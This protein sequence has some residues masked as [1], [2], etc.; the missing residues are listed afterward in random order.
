MASI[1]SDGNLCHYLPDLALG[2][3]LL[4]FLVTMYESVEVIP[5]A[6]L[7]THTKSDV[8][9]RDRMQDKDVESEQ[10]LLTSMKM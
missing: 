4:P 5:G 8:S 3:G 9:A 6:E 2:E 10:G 7:A 1:H